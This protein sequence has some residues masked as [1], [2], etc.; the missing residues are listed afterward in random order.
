VPNASDVR[1]TDEVWKKGDLS[2]HIEKL[3]IA[4]GLLSKRQ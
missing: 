4:F 2:K 1:D 3:A